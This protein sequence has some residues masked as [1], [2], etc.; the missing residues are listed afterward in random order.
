MGQDCSTVYQMAARENQSGQPN[1]L[2]R[3]T[4]NKAL[5][6]TAGNAPV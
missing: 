6:P 4:P 3:R 2:N 5:H 1:L